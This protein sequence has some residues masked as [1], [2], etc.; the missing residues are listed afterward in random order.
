MVLMTLA[1][2]LN[3]AA[4]RGLP[5]NCYLADPD[6]GPIDTAWMDEQ[7]RTLLTQQ[8]PA[9]RLGTAKDTADLVGFLLLPD[10]GWITGQVLQSD[11]GFAD[12]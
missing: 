2:S 5:W 12:K 11:G 3:G 4:L 8:T 6:P 10:G 7:L 1:T 9:G